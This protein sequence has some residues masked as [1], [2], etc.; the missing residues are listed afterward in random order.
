MRQ[1]FAQSSVTALIAGLSL[2][3]GGEISNCSSGRVRADDR[4]GQTIAVAPPARTNPAWRVSRAE[5]DSRI[6]QQA[7]NRATQHKALQVG[8]G[9]FTLLRVVLEGVEPVTPKYLAETQ[10]RDVANID[11]SGRRAVDSDRPRDREIAAPR[12][13]AQT[14]SVPPPTA[15]Y[16]PVVNGVRLFFPEAVG[17]P[18]PKVSVLP[19]KQDIVQVTSTKVVSLQELAGGGVFRE[20]ANGDFILIEHINST[21]RNEGRDPLRVGSFTHHDAEF[22]VPVPPRGQLGILGDVIL[23]RPLPEAMGKIELDLRFVGNEWTTSRPQS[24]YQLQLG[25]CVVGGPYGVTREFNQDDQCDTGLLPPGEYHLLLPDF[26]V[27]KSRW[28]VTIKPGQVTR[29]RFEAS[30]PK[31]VTLSEETWTKR[32]DRKP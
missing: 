20:L 28:T 29:L 4:P 32:P 7:I 14:V 10:P 19:A 21:R 16:S 12:S 17:E 23:S 1:C 5:F 13:E 22:L 31:I 2:L 18:T 30:S 8:A 3:W 15:E 24:K 26:D 25:P 11:E 9:E 27:V 6:W